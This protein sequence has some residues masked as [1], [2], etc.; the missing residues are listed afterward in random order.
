MSH[1]KFSLTEKFSLYI[2]KTS[3]YL[4]D[5]LKDYFGDCD[6]DVEVDKIINRDIS[7][8]TTKIESFVESLA[9]EWIDDC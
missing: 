4:L 9:E 7:N 1:N 2:E 8:Y 5:S 6:Y 3:S